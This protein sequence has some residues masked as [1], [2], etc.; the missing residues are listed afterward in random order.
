[1]GHQHRNEVGKDENSLVDT[2]CRSRSQFWFNVERMEEKYRKMELDGKCSGIE[3]EVVHGDVY[4]PS[5]MPKST[6]SRQLKKL[7]ALNDQFGLSTISAPYNGDEIFGK[8]FKKRQ[9]ECKKLDQAFD[10]VFKSKHPSWRPYTMSKRSRVE[11][12]VVRETVKVTA[13][14]VGAFLNNHGGLI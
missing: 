10:Q 13:A 2:F 8:H 7:D 9:K 11:R 1:M 3:I 6:L 12:T 5:E 4:F 14:R